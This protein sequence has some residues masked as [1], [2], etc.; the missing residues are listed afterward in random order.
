[1]KILKNQKFD[2]KSFLD[3][4]K[5]MKSLG[6]NLAVAGKLMS[7]PSKNLNKLNPE[8]NQIK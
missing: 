7:E 8:K 1:M 6:T 3:L 4:V 5:G 2:S